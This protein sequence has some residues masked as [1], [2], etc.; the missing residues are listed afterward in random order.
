MVIQF[1]FTSSYS[2]R[3]Q[4]SLQIL[5]KYLTVHL[6]CLPDLPFFKNVIFSFTLFFV[7]SYSF[8]NFLYKRVPQM[9]T[10]LFSNCSYSYVNLIPINKYIWNNCDELVFYSAIKFECSVFDWND[11]LKCAFAHSWN[12]MCLN[13]NW[14]FPS[15]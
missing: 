9:E 14:S 12:F 3:K 13:N 1:I 2:W 4:W 15:K 11:N 7:Y 5:N 10:M 8:L 6:H